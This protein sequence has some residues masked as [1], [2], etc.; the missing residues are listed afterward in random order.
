MKAKMGRV[1]SVGRVAI[2]TKEHNGRAASPFTAGRAS[3]A[4]SRIPHYSRPSPCSNAA[5]T[6]NSLSC[7]RRRLHIVMDKSNSR[8]SGIA[9]IDRNTREPKEVR[10]KVVLLCASTLRVDS[11]AAQLR[12]RRRLIPARS[13]AHLMDHVYPFPRRTSLSCPR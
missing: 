7:R 11:P 1:V 3:R 5:A 12:A 10:G 6:G 8:A 4:A 9:Y 13:A 2:L